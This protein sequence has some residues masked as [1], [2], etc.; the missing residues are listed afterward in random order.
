MKR[1]SL[2]LAL[3]FAVGGTLYAQGG[4]GGGPGGGA[5]GRGPGA[6][7]GRGNQGPKQPDDPNSK[8][9]NQ[10]PGGGQ[11]QDWKKQWDDAVNALGWGED[12]TEERVEPGQTVPDKDK[13]A[14]LETEATKLGL[15]EKKVRSDFKKIGLKAWR[16]SEGEDQKWAA[17]YKQNK[18]LKDA[19]SK[20]EEPRKKHLEALK[21]IWDKAD[22]DMTKKKV[23]SEDQ[24]KIW[25]EDTKKMRSETAT[26][27]SAE[28]D[29]IRAR[30][31]DEMRKR[32]LGGQG[33]NEEGKESEKKPKK[34]EESE[35][36]KGSPDS[37]KK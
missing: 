12:G 34:K 16:D 6:A 10:G 25:Q 2:L 28:Q 13:E 18:D 37:E 23:L 3:V 27:K 1:F 31:I 8:S 4:P 26:D 7:G 20:L 17:I 14:W 33:G 36:D 19:D 30:K 15:E 29:K 5:G 9:R 22:E 11:G 24:L 32:Y 35:A 21:K